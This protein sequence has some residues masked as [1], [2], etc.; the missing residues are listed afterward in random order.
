MLC[1]CVHAAT[2]APRSEPQRPR[3]ESSLLAAFKDGWRSNSSSGGAAAPSP[4]DWFFSLAR[5]QPAGQSQS[6]PQTQAQAQAGQPQQL[7]GRR[8]QY[9]PH[10]LSHPQ[11]HLQQLQVG[12]PT[13]RQSSSCGLE[14]V[15]S[16]ALSDASSSP[17]NSS[18]PVHSLRVSIAGAQQGQ[19]QGQGGGSGGG[20]GL[21][22]G[23]G[24][25][26]A[27]ERSKASASSSSRTS[28]DGAGGERTGIGRGGE[29]RG[30]SALTAP[31]EVQGDEQQQ[32]EAG[33]TAAAAAATEAG[34]AQASDQG[35]GPA[36]PLSSSASGGVDF[37]IMPSMKLNTP[38][39]IHGRGAPQ[40]QQ[41]GPS[42]QSAPG[43]VSKPFAPQ[44][45]LSSLFSSSKRSQQAPQHGGGG[46][47]VA[48][49]RAFNEKSFQAQ[50]EEQGREMEASAA[51]GD[52]SGS[53]YRC[54]GWMVWMPSLVCD[55]SASCISH[56]LACTP[57]PSQH[58]FSC[59][60]RVDPGRQ[61]AHKHVHFVT[62]NA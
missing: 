42:T 33:A 22:A 40:S 51:D 52:V 60:I 38:L 15:D 28:V 35:Q 41:P 49:A 7:Q 9:D 6:Q 27:G 34:S 50:L 4:T 57:C 26:V 12:T 37:E 45:W 2:A 62:H 39:I 25:G 31:T 46:G 61:A 20:G 54:G 14:A 3:P 5:P 17:R 24:E 13:G 58:S 47:A 21:A 55:W 30:P 8:L 16:H 53:Y 48:Y 32:G 11:Q 29:R 23:P 56:T 1:L 36:A 19:E 10:P 43:P 44:D 18:S 59:Q